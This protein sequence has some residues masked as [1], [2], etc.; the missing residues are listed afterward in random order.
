MRKEF[1]EILSRYTGLGTGDIVPEMLIAR[2]CDEFDIL[3]MAMDLE[4]EYGVSIPTGILEG[5]LTAGE[6]WA[7]IEEAE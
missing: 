2:Y 3:Q 5:P 4:A 6:L 1:I 7:C